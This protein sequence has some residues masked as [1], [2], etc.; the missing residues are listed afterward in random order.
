MG[1]ANLNS[2]ENC[3]IGGSNVGCPGM[4]NRQF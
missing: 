1:E 2:N 3:F 4:N